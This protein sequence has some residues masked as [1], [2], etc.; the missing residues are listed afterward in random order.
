VLLWLG[1][2]LAWFLLPALLGDA[3]GAV[4]ASAGGW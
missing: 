1:L 4:S 3:W 2:S